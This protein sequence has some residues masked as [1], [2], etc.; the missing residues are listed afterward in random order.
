MSQLVDEHGKPIYKQALEKFLAPA[1]N[2]YEGIMNITLYQDAIAGKGTCAHCL[3][4]IEGVLRFPKGYKLF[5]DADRERDAIRQLSDKVKADH[6]CIA[7]LD[8]KK[9]PVQDFLKRFE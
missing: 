1:E 7:R 5:G 8:A 9:L 4:P 3:G 6:Y 2:V